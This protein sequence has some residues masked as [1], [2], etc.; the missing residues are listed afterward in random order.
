MRLLIASLLLAVATFFSVPAEAQLQFQLANA[1][2]TGTTLNHLA[3]ATGAPSTAVIATTGTTAGVLGV[4]S[5]WTIP[6]G[7]SSATGTTGNAV[8]TF[9]GQAIC[10]FDGT[11][12]AGNWAIVSTTVAGDCHDSGT[13]ST[14]APPAG[15]VGISFTSNTGTGNYI[16][17]FGTGSPTQA[18]LSLSG[19]N[20]FTGNNSFSGTSTW[21]GSL[22]E[23]IRVVTAAGSVTVSSTTDYMIVMNKTSGAAT[24]VN[25]TCSTGFSFLVKDGKG[26][27]ATN[28]IT[29]TPSAGTIDGASTFVMKTS[30][31]ATPPYE[32]RAVTCDS[33]GNSWV[34]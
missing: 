3:I 32:T 24:V 31:A 1:A 22:F 28:N 9:S 7:G 6:A 4:V 2:S 19:N 8:I 17:R 10:A 33:S 18:G 13:A 12:V 21:T 14:A 25:Y 30:V 11:N 5:G 26:D 34:N 15:S 16:V 27:D 20:A 23:P 29:L